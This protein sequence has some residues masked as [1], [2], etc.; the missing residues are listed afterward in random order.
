MLVVE[1]LVYISQSIEHTG[2][3]SQ[4]HRTSHHV[5]NRLRELSSLPVI[6]D[7]FLRREILVM[8]LRIPYSSNNSRTGGNLILFT[9]HSITT[10]GEFRAYLDCIGWVVRLRAP[11]HQS[12]DLVSWEFRTMSVLIG[13]LLHCCTMRAQL[14]P[15]CT[16]QLIPEKLRNHEQEKKNNASEELR[17]HDLQSEL[18]GVKNVFLFYSSACVRSE[19]DRWA[20]ERAFED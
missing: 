5:R 20:L 8:Q 7:S 13:T 16:V 14:P 1:R 9:K 3:C 15:T 17:C 11:D 6:E 18:G 10:S 2:S 4:F 19:H 12:L